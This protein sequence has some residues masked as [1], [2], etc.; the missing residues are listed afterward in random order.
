MACNAVAACLLQADSRATFT[1]GK[2]D[3]KSWPLRRTTFL[4]Q[5]AITKHCASES[6]A[7]CLTDLWGCEWG[8]FGQPSPAF[9][10][11]FNH[12]LRC[13]YFLHVAKVQSRCTCISLRQAVVL[14]TFMLSM[15]CPLHRVHYKRL[16]A[17]NINHKASDPCCTGTSNIET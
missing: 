12:S 4:M 16:A 9:K 15:A 17:Q 13:R 6:S 10:E 11:Q 7:V 5:S 14:P 2:A 1:C 8:R 3:R